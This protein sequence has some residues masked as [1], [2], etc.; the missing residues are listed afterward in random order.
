MRVRT[1]HR[2]TLL[3]SVRHEKVP[4]MLKLKLQLVDR[5][6]IHTLYYSHSASSTSSSMQTIFQQSYITRKKLQVATCSLHIT[7]HVR[8]MRCPHRLL[9]YSHHLYIPA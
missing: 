9:C 7:G 1:E 2:L 3:A 8:K 6:T 4:G 5:R